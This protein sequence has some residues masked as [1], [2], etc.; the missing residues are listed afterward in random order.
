MEKKKLQ[1][2]DSPSDN[3]ST[4]LISHDW[5]DD[6]LVCTLETHYDD[7]YN[8]DEYDHATLFVR[9]VYLQ[10]HK[11]TT[12]HLHASNIYLNSSPHMV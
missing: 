9:D 6:K 8:Q 4:L 11:F 10:K 2:I 3:T 12:L 5:H 7:Y 1:S